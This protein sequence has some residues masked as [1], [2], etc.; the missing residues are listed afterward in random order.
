MR[1]F[2]PAAL[3]ARRCA[4][5]RQSR[6]LVLLGSLELVGGGGAVL[7]RRL[8]SLR[9]KGEGRTCQAARDTG[10]RCLSGAEFSRSPHL[11]LAVVAHAV[12][13]TRP[14]RAA[15]LG[16]CGQSGPSSR[17]QRSRSGPQTRRW[18]KMHGPADTSSRWIS[19]GNSVMAAEVSHTV[20]TASA[21]TGSTFRLR[22]SLVGPFSA[23]LAKRQPGPAG[24]KSRHGA[25]SAHLF[26]RS[27]CFECLANAR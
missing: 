22:W 18:S 11:W 27:S 8:D 5:R 16:A 12:E 6:L 17:G 19:E 4:R 10:E 24:A 21:T 23:R 7:R 2:A 3:R 25:V 20:S 9:R 1:A 15:L 14:A 26:R 13:G